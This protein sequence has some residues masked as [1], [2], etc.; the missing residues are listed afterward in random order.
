[1]KHLAVF[2]ICEI[3]ISIV[4]VSRGQETPHFLV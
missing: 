3:G 1:M 4:S 2:A